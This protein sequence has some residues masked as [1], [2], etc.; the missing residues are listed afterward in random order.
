[1]DTVHKE[2]HHPA[3]AHEASPEGE[4]DEKWLLKHYGPAVHMHAL[5]SSMAVKLDGPRCGHAPAWPHNLF[6]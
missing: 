6:Y 2:L 4:L 3:I 5:I 1:V